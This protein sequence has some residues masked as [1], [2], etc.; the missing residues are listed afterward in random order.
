MYQW[1]KRAAVRDNCIDGI[2]A[3]I[4]TLFALEMFFGQ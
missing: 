1:V 4:P 2:M 3:V